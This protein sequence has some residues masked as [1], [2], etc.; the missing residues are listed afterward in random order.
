MQY[1]P[2]RAETIN[3]PGANSVFYL[4]QGVQRRIDVTLSHESGDELRWERVVDMEIGAALS[5]VCWRG[6]RSMWVGARLCV[7]ADGVANMLAHAL[8]A[9]ADG[10]GQIHREGDPTVSAMNARAL[11]LDLLPWYTSQGC[12]DERY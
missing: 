2:V 8:I 12:G 4:T 5:I 10:P 6:C 11:A 7:C 3:S 1:V 9:V